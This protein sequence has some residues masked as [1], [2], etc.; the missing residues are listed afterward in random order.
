M[1]RGCGHLDCLSRNVIEVSLV[2]LLVLFPGGAVVGKQPAK[3][4]ANGC[5]HTVVEDQVFAILVV[6]LLEIGS[7]IP[8]GEI[9]PLGGQDLANETKG[10]PLIGLVINIGRFDLVLQSS[11]VSLEL[12]NRGLE[13]LV[14]V[15]NT[16]SGCDKGSKMGVRD[17]KLTVREMAG[18]VECGRDERIELVDGWVDG[19]HGGRKKRKD[20]ENKLIQLGL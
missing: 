12:E 10:Q 13:G 2:T 7:E 5:R 9:P 17:I 3:R 18:R 14:V 16:L 20:D 6:E 8:V 11:I 15:L 19:G 4:I 1:G